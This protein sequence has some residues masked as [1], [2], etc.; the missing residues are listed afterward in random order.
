[1]KSYPFTSGKQ[2]WPLQLLCVFWMPS[3]LCFVVSPRRSSN[4]HRYLVRRNMVRNIDLAEAIVFYGRE[5]L[6]DEEQILLPGVEYLLNECERD[7]TVPLALL[8]D[9]GIN[10]FLPSTLKT[11]V[12]SQPPPN[13]RDL[14]EAIHSTVVKPKGFGGSSGFGTKAADPERAPLPQH[15]V[16]LATTED[17]CR[18]ARYAGMRVICT[19]DNDL[20]DAVTDWESICMDDIS[21]PGSFWLNPPHP[22]DDESNSVEPTTI[23]TYYEAAEEKNGDIISS[24]QNTDRDDDNGSEMSDDELAAILADMDPL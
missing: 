16:V 22:R 23:M 11:R 6:F 7:D 1:M 21:T 13:P 19:T 2:R 18:A 8:D 20:A 4:D 5:S 15:T 10:D 12:S 9:G 14:W 3:A 17:Q 24:V